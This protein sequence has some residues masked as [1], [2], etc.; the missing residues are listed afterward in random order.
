[1]S[2]KFH[3]NLT[4]EQATGTAT[5]FLVGVSEDREWVDG[6]DGKRHPG[7][8]I[9]TRYT[10]LMLQSECA[11]LVVKTPE[12]APAVSGEEVATVCLSG[13]FIRVRFEGFTASPY[14]G[15][16]GL[17]ISANA[18][19]CVVVTPAANTSKT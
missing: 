16:N 18:E 14:Q 17:G 10:V 4:C 5:P 12:T 2:N 8:T 6:P 19:K 1:M 3:I 9:G 15:R 7:S 13:N 11:P